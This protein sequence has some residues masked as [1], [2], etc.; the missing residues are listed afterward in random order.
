MTE[1][2]LIFLDIDGVLAHAG[3]DNTLD[4]NCIAELDWLI[5][6]TG[7]EVVLT[8]S[9]RETFGVGETQRRLA[10]AGFRQSI[11]A[12]TPTFPRR[13][14]SDEIDAFLANLSGP[15]RFVILDDVPTASHLVPA[16]VLIDDFTGL[17][18]LEAALAKQLLTCPRSETRSV[19]PAP[20]QARAAQRAGSRER[21]RSRAGAT[22][23]PM[24]R[25]GKTRGK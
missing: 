7:A 16:L 20:R 13:S 11:A 14:R 10:A 9:W 12:V 6:E 19:Q 8:S 3:S 23:L 17:T 24:P 2:R 25:P 22:K 15:A 5:D 4:P 21:A 1:R 18:G